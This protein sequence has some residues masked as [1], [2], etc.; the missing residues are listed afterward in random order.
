MSNKI[1]MIVGLGNPGAE[2]EQTRHNAGFWFI[3]ELA[4]QYKAT[5]KEEKKF[6]GSVARISISGSDL[7]LLKPATFMNRSGQA[8]AALAQFYK[9]KPE[10]ILVV[11][12]ELD[13][14]C[15]RIKFK[16]GGGNGGHNGLKDIQARLGTPDFY[17]LRLGIDHP[18]DRNLVV[19]YVLN[20]P[21]PEHRQQIDEAINKSLKAVPML[22]AGEWE[23]A[24]RFLHSK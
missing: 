17:R 22:L 2:Y 21:S 1:K 14:P 16:L 15:G 18:G 20:K 23:E 19:G 5:L 8:V 6:F 24:V 3:D 13:I 9:I 4:W 7:W 10:E 12:D 11:H